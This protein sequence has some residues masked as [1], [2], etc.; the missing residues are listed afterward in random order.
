MNLTDKI[1][2]FNADC[3]D[4][5]KE[6]PDKYFDLAV[7]DPP[8]RDE[9]KPTKWMMDNSHDQMKS[10]GGRPN[11]KY[12]VELKRVSKEQIIWGANNFGIDFKGFIVWD[13]NI[14]GSNRYS[15]AEIAS[16]S[17]ELSTV[18]IIVKFDIEDDKIHPTQKPLK[19]YDWIFK[20]YAEQGMKILDTHLGSG[21]SAISAD[22]NGL[23]FIGVE[24]DKEYFDAM[25]DR[26]NKYKS[27]MTLF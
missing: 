21:S 1:Q 11:D 15:W 3:M 8:Y 4:I 27:Q 14:R 2:V 23:E 7:V 18:S 13:K 9:N 26:F 19:L 25:V 20:N 6:Y 17:D 22:K 5:M 12:F 10:F 16:T 24:L